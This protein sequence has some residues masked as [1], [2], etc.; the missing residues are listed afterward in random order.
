M[1]LRTLAASRQQK[2]K[3]CHSGAYWMEEGL[4]DVFSAAGLMVPSIIPPPMPFMEE[5]AGAAAEYMVAKVSGSGEEVAPRV[6]ERESARSRIRAEWRQRRGQKTTGA[7]L[8]RTSGA[9]MSHAGLSRKQSL[10]PLLPGTI[11]YP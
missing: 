6:R 7:V 5:V 3:Q 8:I 9:R 10:G 4:P 2:S 11:C 1:H